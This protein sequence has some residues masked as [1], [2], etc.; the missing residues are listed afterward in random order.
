[1]KLKLSMLVLVFSSIISLGAIAGKHDNKQYKVTVT[2]L[3]KGISFTPLLAA[4]H[5]RN[6]S[7]FT[8]GE[9]AS[10]MVSRIAEGGDISM[11]KTALDDSENVL[12]TT[13]SE[14]LLAPGA[15]VELTMMS[16]G[17]YKQISIAAMLLP[18][19]DTMVALLGKALPKK[20]KKVYFLSAYDGGT[21]TNDEYCNNIPGSHC[22]GVPFSPDDAGEGYI[23][24][25]PAIHGEADL[26][27]E[28]Y[29][30][31]GAVAK[32]VIEVVK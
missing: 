1:M 24:P 11:L 21:E 12:S 4:T 2:N 18:T 20:G 14:G 5:N 30:W 13:N 22:G 10:E 25:S 29:N 15:S 17:K 32:V 19:N 27:R 23:Y 3:T 7:F 9:P 16:S 26:S 8:L 28:I 6:V 31:D